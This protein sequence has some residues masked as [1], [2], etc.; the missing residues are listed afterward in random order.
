MAWDSISPGSSAHCTLSLTHL[1][2]FKQ[3]KG[4]KVGSHLSLKAPQGQ[5]HCRGNVFPH[6][7]P[8]KAGPSSSEAP[9]IG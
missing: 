1:K 9:E 5:S 7:P 4:I 6:V 3:H 8:G 2:L